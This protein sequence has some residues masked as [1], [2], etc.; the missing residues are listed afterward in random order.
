M[1]SY[2]SPEPLSQQLFDE[3]LKGYTGH[4]D[5]EAVGLIHMGARV[6]DPMLGRFLSPDP[7]VMT[8]GQTANPYTYVSN[9]P[10]TISDPGAW[11]WGIFRSIGRLF[12]NIGKAIAKAFGKAIQAV[13]HF[14]QKNL[15][16]RVLLRSVVFRVVADVAITMAC[17]GNPGCA[18]EFEAVTNGLATKLSGGSWKDAVGAALVSFAEGSVPGL[19]ELS[20]AEQLIA[21]GTI[22]GAYSKLV[23]HSSF[24]SGFVSGAS[25]YGVWAGRSVETSLTVAGIA[26]DA[27]AATENTIALGVYQG[28]VKDIA[29]SLHTN[30]D[31]L[32]L[33]L[34]GA[35]WLGGVRD[36]T[37]GGHQVQGMQSRSG[38]N[39]AGTTLFDVVDTVLAYQ[40][41]PTRTGWEVILNPEKFSITAGHSLGA[42]ETANLARYGFAVGATL[43]AMPLGM[44]GGVNIGKI[45]LNPGDPVV[46]FAA[47]FAF[48]PTAIA[49][50]DQSAFPFKLSMSQAHSLPYVPYGH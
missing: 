29:K 49:T 3:E 41:L 42:L 38:M 40:G 43:Y 4:F 9:N 33:G 18:M 48:H 8:E 2:K 13:T 20:K 45:Y 36:I 31:V 47:G 19:G 27:L 30:V 17:G 12:S 26:K 10:L 46:G 44:P 32:D 24:I 15:N 11:N 16:L 39:R 35:S 50:Q 1:D 23:Q 6:Y 34:M 21:A 14:I 37:N 28:L 25:M 7:V 5:L 22:G